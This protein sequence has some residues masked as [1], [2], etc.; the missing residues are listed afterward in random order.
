MFSK[1]IG[2]YTTILKNIYLSI[3]TEFNMKHTDFRKDGKHILGNHKKCTLSSFKTQLKLGNIWN[4]VPGASYI[5][6]ISI[7]EHS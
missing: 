3:T 6:N 5:S 7:K 2:V 4:I 1:R